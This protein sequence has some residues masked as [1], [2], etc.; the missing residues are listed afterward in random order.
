M[1]AIRAADIV[2]HLSA[3]EESQWAPGPG[4][5]AIT[6]HQIAQLLK[7]LGV[8][9]HDKRDGARVAKCYMRQEV[10]LAYDRYAA[11][12]IPKPQQPLHG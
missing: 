1:S 9:S 8:K 12:A 10:K 6:P 3:L 5:R 2:Q 11:P 7:P 4:S